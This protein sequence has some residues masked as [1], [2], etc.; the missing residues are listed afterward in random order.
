MVTLRI[1]TV[2]PTDRRVTLDLPADVPAGPAELVVTVDPHTADRE[3]ARA[4]ALAHFLALARSSPFRSAG[5]YP[6]RA[7]L[8][9]RD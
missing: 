3:R 1:T 4:D 6:P 5:P 7:E 9:E 2:V 8:Y